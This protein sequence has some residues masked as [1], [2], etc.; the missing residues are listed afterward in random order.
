M[1]RS[2]A[3]CLA[4]SNPSIDSSG[5]SRPTTSAASWLEALPG[6]SFALPKDRRESF[7]QLSGVTVSGVAVSGEILAQPL[8]KPFQVRAER[9]GDTDGSLNHRIPDLYSFPLI[10]SSD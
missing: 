9:L 5:A 3:R 8:V 10:E 4:D 1:K 6:E 7:V 2:F